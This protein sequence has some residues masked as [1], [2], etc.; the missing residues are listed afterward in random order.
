MTTFRALTFDL[1]SQERYGDGQTI[2]MHKVKVK[3]H[4][5]RTLE[6]KQMD[7]GDYITYRTLTVM[8]NW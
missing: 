8:S 6:W 2:H 4:S 1:Q 5:V 3:S 7:G